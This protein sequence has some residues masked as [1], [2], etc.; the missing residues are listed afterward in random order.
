[1]FAADPSRRAQE[2]RRI[3]RSVAYASR[4]CYSLELSSSGELRFNLAITRV[5][6]IKLNCVPNCVFRFLRPIQFPQRESE[7]APA[8]GRFRKE[9]HRFSRSHLAFLPAPEL[10]Q[11]PCQLQ[12]R[13]AVHRRKLNNGQKMVGC[14]LPISRHSVTYPGYKRGEHLVASRNLKKVVR[15]FGLAQNLRF[16]FI[17]QR[18]PA[19]SAGEIGLLLE[20]P[21]IIP[22]LAQ[23]LVVAEDG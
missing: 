4:V 8:G 20:F 12:P 21:K 10:G 13:F 5:R 11:A 22:H 2:R 15:A 19:F 16:E 17:H 14:F 6:W 9:F 18:L 7:V 1:M 3:A 23:L